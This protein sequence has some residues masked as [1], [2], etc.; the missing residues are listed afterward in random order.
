[1]VAFKL[2]NVGVSQVALIGICAQVHLCIHCSLEV[3]T[4]RRPHCSLS[5]FKRGIIERGINF[6]LG[7]IVTE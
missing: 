5:V 2:P 6:L 1:M 3:E 4:V 7:W